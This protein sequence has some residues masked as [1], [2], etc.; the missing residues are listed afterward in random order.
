[1]VTIRRG[2][3]LL[4]TKINFNEITMLSDTWMTLF[5]QK[6]VKE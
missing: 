5:N 3:T 1:M 2:N 6:V 4:N